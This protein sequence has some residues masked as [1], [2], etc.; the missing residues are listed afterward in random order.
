MIE[1]K[2]VNFPDD[3]YKSSKIISDSFITVADEFGLTRSNCPTNPAFIEP[4]KMDKLLTD[5]RELYLLYYIQKAVGFVAIEKSQTEADV[6][7]IEK[8][9]VIP[10]YRHKG[11]GKKIME[12][13][14]ERILELG[15]KRA[16]IAIIDENTR[17][18][19]WYKILGFVATGVKKFDHLPFTVCFMAKELR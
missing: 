9:S 10:E 11:M 18:K 8:V 19:D 17:L 14:R 5:Y 13:A 12:F 16:S 15:G 2:P 7:Y 6:F 4:L 3:L 1:F